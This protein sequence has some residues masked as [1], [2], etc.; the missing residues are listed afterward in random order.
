MSRA[1]TL[2]PS[3]LCL[4]IGAVVLAHAPVAP[5]RADEREA[6]MVAA[7]REAAEVAA[8]RE[9]A[10]VAAAIA[11]VIPYGVGERARYRVSWGVTGRVGTGLMHIEAIDTIRGRPAFRI[12]NTLQ[13]RLL[14]ARVNNRFE[15]W[16]DVSGVYSHR[17]EQWTHEVNF[18][19]RRTREFFPAESRWS[20][21]TN[22]HPEAGMLTTRQPLDDTSFLYFVRTLDLVVGRE[23]TYDRYWNPDGNP[24]RI[25]VLRRERVT[26]PAGTFD[27]IVIQ[28]VIRTSGM[29]AEGGEAEVYF[30]EGGARQLVKLRARLPIG[31]LQLQLEEFEPAR[32]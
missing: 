12:V 6:A 25:R 17:F 26:V 30:A 3:A 22:G 24:V 2:L 13:G 14:L 15:S 4:A 20:G 8:A 1:A 32:R 21:Q 27:T 7:A 10:V 29:F 28:P 5:L 11:N 31:T 19:R 18:R 16:L 23:Y 9:A